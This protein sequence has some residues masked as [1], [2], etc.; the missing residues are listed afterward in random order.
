MEKRQNLN[1]IKVDK[2]LSIANIKIRKDEDV[3]R[4]VVSKKYNKF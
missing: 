2:I 1:D 3:I 4:E